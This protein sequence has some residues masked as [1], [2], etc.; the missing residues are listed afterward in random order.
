MPSYG[1]ERTRRSHVRS[2]P[3]RLPQYLVRALIYRVV[4]DRLFRLDESP[5][6][7]DQDRYVLPVALAIAVAS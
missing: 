7:D 6:P 5:R 4:T 1:K 2:T 3:I